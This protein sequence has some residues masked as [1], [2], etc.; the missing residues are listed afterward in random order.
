M[1]SHEQFPDLG[2]VDVDHHKGVSNEPDDDYS[3][4][5]AST[6]SGTR[7]ILRTDSDGARPKEIPYLV[8]E[9]TLHQ[10]LQMG[11]ENMDPSYF[12]EIS[13]VI[14]CFTVFLLWKALQ[15]PSRKFQALSFAHM[16]MYLGTLVSMGLNLD[17]EWLF[18]VCQ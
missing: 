13:R 4:T 15:K 18:L 1:S 11:Q 14:T 10:S 3:P 17:G 16:L 6:V 9:A 12:K 2:H 5:V 7:N 8:Q